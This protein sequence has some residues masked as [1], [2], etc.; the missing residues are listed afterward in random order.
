M[1]RG[2]AGLLLY[3]FSSRAE[4]KD[5]FLCLVRSCADGPLVFP[6]ATQKKPGTIRCRAGEAADQIWS[7]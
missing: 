3:P 2:P 5:K 4:N 7:G 6:P 1:K